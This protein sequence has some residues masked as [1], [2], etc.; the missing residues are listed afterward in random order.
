MDR[1]SSSSDPQTNGTK[2]EARLILF[3]DECGECFS[4]LDYLG[5]H[6]RS[7]H[8]ERVQGKHQCS[9][10]SY[11]SN[12]RHRVTS[13]ERT[14][15]GERPYVCKVCQ[16]GFAQPCTLAAHMDTHS[17]Q[18]QHACEVCDKRYRSSSSLASHR[19]LH[20]RDAKP[21]VCPE[22]LRGFNQRCVLLRHL[23]THSG[24]K[25]HVCDECGRRFTQS[26]SANR[27]RRSAHSKQA[28]APA[29]E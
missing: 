17:E 2:T 22:C 10:C 20:T 18:K 3:C 14:H 5:R 23:G 28:T 1:E 12:D 9:Y 11:S 13:H 25:P 27:H 6:R 21:Y 7:R 15:T 26:G 24:L 19:R 16:K 8:R 4:S 29:Q